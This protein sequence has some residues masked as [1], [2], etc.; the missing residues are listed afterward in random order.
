MKQGQAPDSRRDAFL[1]AM[2]REVWNNINRHMTVVWQ[3]AGVLAGAFALFALVDKGAFNVDVASAL[4]VLIASWLVAHTYDA[5]GWFSRNLV[6][7]ANIERQFLRSSDDREIHFFF[8]RH[9]GPQ[10]HVESPAVDLPAG[11]HV[12][13][14]LPSGVHFGIPRTQVTILSRAIR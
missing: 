9:R 7:V 4:L 10:C 11:S 2:Y 3:S 14:A 5:N 6:I 8:K 13:R 12:G 1:L